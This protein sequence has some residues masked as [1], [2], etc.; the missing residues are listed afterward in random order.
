MLRTR[1]RLVCATLFSTL[2]V[3]ALVLVLTLVGNRTGGTTMAQADG[4]GER[5]LAVNFG[6]LSRWDQSW[7][8]AD[9]AKQANEWQIRKRLPNEGGRIDFRRYDGALTE[10]GWPN[11]MPPRSQWR[12][13]AIAD[14]GGLGTPGGTWVLTW[15]GGGLVE[16]HDTNGPITPS[17]GSLRERRLEY[18]LPPGQKFLFP[19]VTV[20]AQGDRPTRLHLWLPGAE[21]R[22]INPAVVNRMRDLGV[23]AIRVMD[24]THTNHSL[25]RSWEDR[26]RP[27][28]MLQ[29]TTRGAAWNNRVAAAQGSQQRWAAK[30]AMRDVARGTNRDRTGASWEACIQLANEV[31]A[32]LYLCVPAEADDT[33]LWALADLLRRNLYGRVYVEYSNEY[34]NS[35]FEQFNYVAAK[36]EE[37][38]PP[39]KNFREHFYGKRAAEVQR[40][41]EQH[42]GDERVTFVLG[43]QVDA[44]NLWNIEQTTQAF[45]ASGGSLDGEA[46]GV[47]FYFHRGLTRWIF[48]QGLHLRRGDARLAAMDQAFDEL[49]RRLNDPEDQGWAKVDQHRGFAEARGARLIGYEGGSHIIP[50]DGGDPAGPTKDNAELVRFILQMHEHPRMGEMTLLNKKL[51][52]WHGM[53]EQFDFVLFGKPGRHGAWG[54]QRSVYLEESDRLRAL[55]QW[56]RGE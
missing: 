43:A 21:G 44:G 31:G 8:L 35:I 37:N 53:R 5:I 22:L 2:V 14:N 17:R 45:E 20:S 24:I 50:R 42:L 29:G 27:D 23:D 18:D 25:D 30:T 41:M 51:A 10:D 36:A 54:H 48:D 52:E 6:G 3:S 34:W 12:L 33:Y 19:A 11:V 26:S 38:T 47:T 55:R 39:L 4:G 49:T 1:L 16:L 46:I 40:I 28:Y 13:L 7:L 32:D 9:A 15:E 56:K